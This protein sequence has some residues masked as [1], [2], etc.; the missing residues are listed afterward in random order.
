MLLTTGAPNLIFAFGVQMAVL[1]CGALV[2][3]AVWR[4]LGAAGDSKPK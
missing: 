4:I 1:V 3:V 2:G